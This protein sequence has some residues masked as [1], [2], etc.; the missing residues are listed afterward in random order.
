VQR[1]IF[2]SSFVV[3]RNLGKR[4]LEW[5][6]EKK[7]LR[8]LFPQNPVCAFRGQKCWTYASGFAHVLR[9]RHL[10][11]VDS[12]ERD[13]NIRNVIPL[14]NPCHDYLDVELGEVVGGQEIQRLIDSLKDEF[15]LGDLEDEGS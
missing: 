14:C 6:A 11:K 3:L 7:V 13:F 5:I 10:G 4:G 12:E 8:T 15:I 9:R 2:C 1:F